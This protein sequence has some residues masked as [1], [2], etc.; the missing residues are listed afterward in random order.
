[1]EDI[2]RLAGLVMVDDE[3]LVCFVGTARFL[4]NFC[5]S[6]RVSLDQLER[7]FSCP[8]NR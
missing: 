5:E 7:N 2:A 3:I 1:M 6:D 8:Y 4:N